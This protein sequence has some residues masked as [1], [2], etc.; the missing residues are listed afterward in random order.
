[1][2]LVSAG[3]MLNG[4]PCKTAVGIMAAVTDYVYIHTSQIL[5]TNMYKSNSL[6]TKIF[7]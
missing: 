4:F 6:T 7:I 2:A 1:M 5:S 3:L